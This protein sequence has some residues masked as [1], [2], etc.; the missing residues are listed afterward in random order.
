MVICSNTHVHLELQAARAIVLAKPLSPVRSLPTLC[1]WFITYS[2]PFL[3]TSPTLPKLLPLY[4][5]VTRHSDI[6]CLTRPVTK[7]QLASRVIATSLM[8]RKCEFPIIWLDCSIANSPVLALSAMP[9]SHHFFVFPPKSGTVSTPTFS[10]THA[11]TFGPANGPEAL[12][13]SSNLTKPSI[14]I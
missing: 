13:S 6:G 5:Q 3:P 11:T 1:F 2:L 8:A 4:Q 12:T 7:L 9:S 14:S 10:A